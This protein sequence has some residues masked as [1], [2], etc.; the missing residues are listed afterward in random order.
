MTEKQILIKEIL[1]YEKSLQNPIYEPHY[2]TIEKWL[3]DAK[4]RL[5]KYVHEDKRKIKK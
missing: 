4:E 5:N 1:L 2:Q 3:K